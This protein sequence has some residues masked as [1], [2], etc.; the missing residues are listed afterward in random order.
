MSLLFPLMFALHDIYSRLVSVCSRDTR[1]LLLLGVNP[2]SIRGSKIGVF[3]G[4]APSESGAAWTDDIDK[5]TGHEMV[6]NLLSM[7]ANKLSYFFDFTGECRGYD[8]CTDIVPL[9][10]Y[11]SRLEDDS[12]CTA[13]RKCTVEAVWGS[14][15]PTVTV[16]RR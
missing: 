8:F 5:L 16:D 15:R 7:T 2:Q 14:S 11:V 10:Y 6:G 12:E 9:V 3:V 1:V 4:E 13:R